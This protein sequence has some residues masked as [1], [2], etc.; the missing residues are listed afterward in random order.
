MVVTE[1]HTEM[2]T[3]SHLKS[4]IGLTK[5]GVSPDGAGRAG[6][7]AGDAMMNCGHV[8]R[9]SYQRSGLVH[10]SFEPCIAFEFLYRAN[11]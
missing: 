7:K 11:S 3:M 9:K 8:S 4:E 2:H 6:V 10:G 5:L 1:R